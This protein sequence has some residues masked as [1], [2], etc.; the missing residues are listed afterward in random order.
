MKWDSY[1]TSLGPLLSP[2]QKSRNTHPRVL[3][4]P[5]TVPLGWVMLR[6]IGGAPGPGVWTLRGRV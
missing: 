6:E 4:A 2:L 3:P 1:L 5:I